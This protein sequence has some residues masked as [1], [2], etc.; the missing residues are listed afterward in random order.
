MVRARWNLGSTRD[1]VH[2]LRSRDTWAPIIKFYKQT[3]AEFGNAQQ[4]PVYTML[5]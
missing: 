1:H 4:F 5:V 2:T 3:N